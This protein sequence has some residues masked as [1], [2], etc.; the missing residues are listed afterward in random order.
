MISGTFTEQDQ[1]SKICLSQIIFLIFLFNRLGNYA[2]LSLIKL[3]T[4]KKDCWYGVKQSEGSNLP[5]S[6]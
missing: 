3:T 1:W 2:K 6:G 4:A 5:D